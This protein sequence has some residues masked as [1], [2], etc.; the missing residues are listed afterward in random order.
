MLEAG[1]PL[2]VQPM[3]CMKIIY[4]FYICPS[5]SQGS[6][7]Y[8]SLQQPFDCFKKKKKTITNI[9]T[10][11]WIF[12]CMLHFNKTHRMLCSSLSLFIN[13]LCCNAHFSA[14]NQCTFHCSYPPSC[15]NK[16][17]LFCLKKEWPKKKN[18]TTSTLDCFDLLTKLT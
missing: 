16:N 9:S 4:C 8:D 5:A 7:P 6:N 11:E 13:N 15:K 12:S 2:M 14:N 3:R 1:S 10:V 17:N 18:H